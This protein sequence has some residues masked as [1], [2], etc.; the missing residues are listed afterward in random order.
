MIGDD[1]R[2]SERL[3]ARVTAHDELEPVTQS[4]SITTFRYVPAE[5]RT[6]VGTVEGDKYLDVL[7]AAL[8]ERIQQS[9]EAF[10]SN[11]VVRGRYLLRACI[12]N[13]NTE[14]RD[15]DALPEIVV[16]LGR[17]AHV[18]LAKTSA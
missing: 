7:N 2:L 4:L 10:V 12:V 16:R 1:V 5:L 8:L 13:I 11:A 6:T 17:E 15:V 14:A 18:A 9:G 3:H